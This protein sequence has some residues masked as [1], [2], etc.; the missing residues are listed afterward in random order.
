MFSPLRLS[1]TRFWSSQLAAANHY[2]AQFLKQNSAES[3][4]NILKKILLD[5]NS[6]EFLGLKSRNDD[7][8]APITQYDVQDY[9][10]KK[11]ESETQ[12]QIDKM[13]LHEVFNL[14]PIYN[15]L[16]E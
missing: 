4:S 5:D 2:H 14:A 16:A 6:P 8:A 3:E 9:V 1:G 7:T 12:L 13:T 15:N 11:I 10:R